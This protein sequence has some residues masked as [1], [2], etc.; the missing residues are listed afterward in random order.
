MPSK[1]R[2][3]P[4]LLAA[5]LLKIRDGLGLSQSEMVQRIG[6]ENEINRGKISEYER[7]Q[8]IPPLHLLLAYS[9][10]GKVTLEYLV[11]DEVEL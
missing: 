5:K 9:R 2:K 10:A 4:A 11:D 1:S 8:R 6:A 3:S 7:S